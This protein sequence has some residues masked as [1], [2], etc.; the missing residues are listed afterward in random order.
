MSRKVR[1]IVIQE[2]E[3]APDIRGKKW[4]RDEEL[5]LATYYGKKSPA[6]IADYL[7]KSPMAIKHHSA[8]IGVSYKT[9]DEER[10]EILRKL[11]QEEDPE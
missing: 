11:Q 8:I 6:S 3:D 4:S 5:I 10:E 2:L 9:T 7:K 1:K